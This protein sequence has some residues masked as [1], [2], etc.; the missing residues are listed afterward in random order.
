VFQRYNLVSTL[1]AL[2]NVILPV[3]PLRTGYDK[4]AKAGELLE[5]V[6]LGDRADARPGELSGGQQQRVAIAR[7]LIV[8]PAVVVA[9]EPTGSLD[10]ATAGHIVDLLTRVCGDTGAI[11]IMATHDPVVASRCE[12]ILTLHDGR[13]SDDVTL[14]APADP[15]LT[16]QALSGPS[17]PGRA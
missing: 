13:I 1:T 5:R 2:D 17:D 14:A 6:G 9:D 15:D 8:D 10:S 4:R 7:A 3:L 11:L 16:W 12:R